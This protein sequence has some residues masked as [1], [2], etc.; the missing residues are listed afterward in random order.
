MAFFIPFAAVGP[1]ISG[2]VITPALLFGL[3]Y[4]STVFNIRRVSPIQVALLIMMVG[5]LMTSLGK[6]SFGSYIPS[7]LA[8]GASI[9]PVSRAL[10]DLPDYRAFFDGFKAGLVFTLG[11]IGLEIASQLAGSSEL[12]NTVTGLLRN[13]E[14]VIRT[15][16]LYIAYYRPYG[17]MSEP[18]HLAL[19]FV[20]AFVF[21]D[22]SGT[23]GL[24]RR[25]TLLAILLTG[26]ISGILLLAVYLAVRF[27]SLISV[28]HRVNYGR[29]LSAM[30]ATVLAVPLLV[31]VWPMI[32]DTVDLIHGRIYQAVLAIQQVQL[33][34]SEAS[35]A[36]AHIALTT[37]WRQGDLWEILF[38]TGYANYSEWIEANFQ[39]F[40]A[41]S[42]LA[43]GEVINMLVAV[44]LSTG[45]FGATLF[46]NL[47]RAIFKSHGAG[48]FSVIGLFALSFQFFYGT[49][50]FYFYWYSLFSVLT[51]YKF[52]SWER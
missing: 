8:L 24:L 31:L 3:L 15:H 43:Q 29:V 42:A 35:R 21:L 22:I 25:L 13:S 32:V 2:F 12:Y 4:G 14:S 46:F 28:R 38:G 17:L 48:M 7:L 5:F 47:L 9:F 37:Y 33:I 19:Y 30:I 27:R 34:G 36:N 45:L 6:H 10:K 26:S 44:T 52:K 40:G 18:A 16:N 1:K 11:F 39:S 49:M 20:S 51:A 41:R 50:V 23:H